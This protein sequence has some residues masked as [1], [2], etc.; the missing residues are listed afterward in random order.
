LFIKV[1][2]CT[3]PHGLTNSERSSSLG[4]SARLLAPEEPIAQ[5][6]HFEELRLALVM[7]GGVSLAVRMSGVTNEIRIRP[8]QLLA[9]GVVAYDLATASPSLLLPFVLLVAVILSIRFLWMQFSIGLLAIIGGGC[10]EAASSDTY[11]ARACHGFPFASRRHSIR[12][13]CPPC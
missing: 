6:D 5:N 13:G 11:S 7:N 9:V 12:R 3:Q 10:G 2:C 4:L 1:M 8:V